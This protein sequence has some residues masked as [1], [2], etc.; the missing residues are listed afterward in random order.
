[1]LAER[2]Q[3]TTVKEQPKEPQPPNHREVGGK[4]NQKVETESG[5]LWVLPLQVHRD[6]LFISHAFNL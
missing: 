3:Q 2:C 1:M 5:S 4:K 6:V